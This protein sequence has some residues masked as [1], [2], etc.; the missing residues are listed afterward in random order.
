MGSFND[1]LYNI[2][3]RSDLSDLNDFKNIANKVTS[4]MKAASPQ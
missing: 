4:N 3:S 2:K 1:S